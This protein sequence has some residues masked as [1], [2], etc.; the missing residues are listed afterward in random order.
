MNDSHKRWSVPYCPFCFLLL[1]S[2]TVNVTTELTAAVLYELNLRLYNK[3]GTA[4]RY[5]SG[6]IVGPSDKS[7]FSCVL[8]LIEKK[9]ALNLCKLELF[10]LLLPIE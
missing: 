9:K 3:H 5:N 8:C 7:G 2:W 4:Q 1:L 10:G 6:N